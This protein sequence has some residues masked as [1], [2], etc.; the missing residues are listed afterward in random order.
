VIR[1]ARKDANHAE[2]VACFR[3]L[4]WSVLDIS[5][6]KNCADIVVARNGITFV[7][8]IK[9]GTKPPSARKLTDGEQVFKD[10][11]RGHYAIITSI[12]DALLLNSQHF[13]TVN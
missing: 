10:G 8:E 4:G 9:D 11:W 1:N 3:K 6:L 2:I 5:Q 13:G 12:G 7:I